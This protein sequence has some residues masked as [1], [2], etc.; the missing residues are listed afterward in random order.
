M[1]NFLK[2]SKGGGGDQKKKKKKHREKP[3]QFKKKHHVHS[4]GSSPDNKPRFGEPIRRARPTPQKIFIETHHSDSSAPKKNQNLPASVKEGQRQAAPP[5]QQISRPTPPPLA[6]PPQSIPSQTIA[7]TAQPQSPD[8]QPNRFTF[9][10]YLTGVRLNPTPP[11]RPNLFN[12]P[13]PAQPLQRQQMMVR[14]PPSQK[15]QPPSVKNE[16]SKKEL[17]SK[18]KLSQSEKKQKSAETVAIKK[19]NNGQSTEKPDESSVEPKNKEKEQ[20]RSSTA[21]TD[22]EREAEK[23]KM[24]VRYFMKREAEE[25]D[26]QFDKFR[27]YI[28]KSFTRYLFDENPEKCRFADIICMDQTRI[29]LEDC[30]EGGFIHANWVSMNK[31][32]FNDRFI[33]SQFPNEESTFDF[34]HMLWQEKVTTIINI[35]T[36]EEWKEYGD[37]IGLLPDTGRCRHVADGFTVTFQKEVNCNPEY[38]V[39]IYGIIHENEYRQI[40]WITYLGWPEGKCPKDTEAILQILSLTKSQRRPILVMSMAGAGRAGTYVSLEYL[41]S[42]L[43]SLKPKKLS[44]VECIQKIRDARLHSVQTIHQFKFIFLVLIDHILAVKKLRNDIGTEI[45]QKY[46]TLKQNI[47]MKT[48]EEE[49]QLSKIILPENP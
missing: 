32:N 35:M 3:S 40:L 1:F 30:A 36:M 39:V 41:H 2:S 15:L 43:H 4:R 10:E 7:T 5:S 38:T 44:I 19:N 23:M 20:H 46:E 34:W 16:E 22:R 31:D 14:P 17:Q 47:L 42:L 12:Q 45:V 9:R 48:W 26:S 11:A 21:K 33:V 29:I 18:S 27:S 13:S 28:P 8:N 25:L 37:P 24:F 6:Q 49:K